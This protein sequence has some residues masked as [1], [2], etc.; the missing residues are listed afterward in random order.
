MEG[1]VPT[2]LGQVG[3]GVG[4]RGAGTLPGAGG[5]REAAWWSPRPVL[6]RAK[7]T[8][9]HHPSPPCA[10]AGAQGL[11][12][13]CRDQTTWTSCLKKVSRVHGVGESTLSRKAHS[14]CG[15]TA[16]AWKKRVD[17]TNFTIRGW[18][19]GGRGKYRKAAVFTSSFSLS[20]FIVISHHSVRK[21]RRG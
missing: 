9:L 12:G 3:P 15:F 7:V 13:D 17:K 18:S 16:G 2:R 11:S 6:N 10:R 8:P 21:G 5:G 1:N 19:S 20:L 4:T 14:F